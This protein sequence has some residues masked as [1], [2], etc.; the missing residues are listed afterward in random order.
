[1]AT[2][3][4]D[5]TAPE[6]PTSSAAVIA[7]GP[8]SARCHAEVTAAA[9]L[10]AQAQRPLTTPYGQRS[11]ARTAS[12]SRFANGGSGHMAWGVWAHGG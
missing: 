1:M 6:A 9:F 3:R 8:M 2:A 4:A 12:G 11:P 7:S 5:A 10:D